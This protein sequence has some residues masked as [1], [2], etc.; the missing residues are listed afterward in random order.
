MVINTRENTKEKFRN[1]GFKVL[2]TKTNFI[3]VTH[4]EITGEEYH[5]KLRK[6]GVLTRYY[7]ESRINNY[8]RI[9]IGTDED[10]EKVV[11]ITEKIL[12][13][14]AGLRKVI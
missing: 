7:D 4:H 13:E 11:E 8:V 1:L 5:K 2:D 10:M 9:T 6:N 3:F 14:V 12:K